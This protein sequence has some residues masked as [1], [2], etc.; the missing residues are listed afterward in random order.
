[1]QLLDDNLFSLFE[2]G[3]ISAEE[4][5]DAAR[6]PGEITNRVHRA[7]KTVGRPELDLEQE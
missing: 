5:V 4:M 2:R 7:G 1:M 6:D 3:M